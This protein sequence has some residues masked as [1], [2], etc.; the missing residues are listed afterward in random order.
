MNSLRTQLDEKREQV[1]KDLRDEIAK[2]KLENAI[3]FRDETLRFRIRGP[4]AGDWN[5]IILTKEVIK[6]MFE[7][8]HKD[9][10]V[11]KVEIDETC[12]QI[13]IYVEV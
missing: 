10:K 12:N 11:R 7:Q 5:F 3:G 8:A 1:W 13:D 4:R 9:T 2:L 6:H